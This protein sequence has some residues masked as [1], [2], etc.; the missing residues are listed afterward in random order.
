MALPDYSGYNYRE[1]RQSQ[2]RDQRADMMGRRKFRNYKKNYVNPPVNPQL[3]PQDPGY[4]G[5]VSGPQTNNQHPFFDPNSNYAQTGRQYGAL[6]GGPGH[7]A[8]NIYGTDVNP[9]GYYYAAL[10]ERGLGGLDARSQAAQGMYKDAALG[11]QA[12]KT[13]NMELWFPEY[14]EQWDVNSVLD[15]MSEEQL[16]IDR[17]RFTG[18]DR[19][20]M[21]GGQ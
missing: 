17:S 5:P 16:G 6:P 20:G 8:T 14:L 7:S 12:A 19:W 15:Q 21:R 3:P 4:Q 11:Y 2:P 9:Q 18:R 13:R 10:N 1:Y